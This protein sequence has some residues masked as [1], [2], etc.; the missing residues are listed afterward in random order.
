VARREGMDASMA[1][2]TRTIEQEFIE[3]FDGSRQRALQ[4]MEIYP[5][6]VTHDARY[7][8]PFP[9]YIR[10]AQGAKK[11]DVDGHELID[12]AVGH[13]SLILGHNHPEVVEAV[14]AQLQRGT[15]FGAGHDQELEWGD[16]VQRLVPSA[17]RVKFTS[18]GT[19]A[20]M[21]AIRAARAFSGHDKILKFA[22]HFHGWHDYVVPGEKVP[23]GATSSPG[24]PQSSFDLTVV[25]P[26]DDLDFVEQQLAH[27]D[28]AAVILEPSGASW[29]TI[30]PR[31]G[32]L[33]QLRELTRKYD[34]ILIFDEVI[35]G[36]RWAPGGAQ[37]RFKITPDMTTLAKIV[38]GGLPGGAIA[39]RADIMAVFEFRD[40]PGWKK[41]VHPGTYNANPLSAVAG[42][43]CLR[44]VSD[45][46]VQE[47]ADAM[48]ARLRAGFNAALVDRG[49]PGVC[50]GEA[51]V[52]HVILGRECSNM[53]AGDVRRPEGIEPEVLKA[54]LTGKLK[55]VFAAGMLL[56]GSDLT[57][58][59]GW[60]SVQHTPEDI[61]RTIAGFDR[62][63]V[64]IRD[65]G[66]L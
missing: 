14:M 18:S 24:I 61:D 9:I 32:F 19:E 44:L 30:P 7:V 63:I 55:N 25:A 64:R 66:L 65:E 48:A 12:Y 52:F 23:F 22:G 17:A 49:I 43:T 21:L 62:T 1:Q 53:T 8:K 40:E 2:A 38:A 35:T 50:Y 56:E 3:T 33:H 28:I 57:F 34:T 51:S 36:F 4:A 10:S 16:W 6:G 45:P 37:E 15:H 5:A 41:I 54:G 31:E 42:A 13:G 39:G 59:G 27:G 58:G 11:I 46:K 29:A 26:H 60:L 20:T 47:H